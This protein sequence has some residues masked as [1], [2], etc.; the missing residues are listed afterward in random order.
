[1]QKRLALRVRRA[2]LEMNQFEVAAAAG[3]GR[4]RFCRIELGYA[5]PTPDEQK[6]IAKALKA[7]RDDLFGEPAGVGR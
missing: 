4:D 5:D 7:K 2:A 1:M 6:A 3:I